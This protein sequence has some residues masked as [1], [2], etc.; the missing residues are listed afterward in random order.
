VTENRDRMK[1]FWNAETVFVDWQ[2][3]ELSPED[4]L[5]YS[6]RIRVYSFSSTGKDTRIAPAVF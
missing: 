5:Q 2:E 1:F 4:F 6:S 3:Q